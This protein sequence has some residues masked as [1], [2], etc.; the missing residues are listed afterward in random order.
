[1]RDVAGRR[2]ADSHYHDGHSNPIVWI[3]GAEG[4]YRFMTSDAILVTNLRRTRYLRQADRP[5]ATHNHLHV[6]A[7]GP[8]HTIRTR[9]RGRR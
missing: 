7:D 8:V 6:G 2:V 3:L 1:M 9:G 5:K 4:D